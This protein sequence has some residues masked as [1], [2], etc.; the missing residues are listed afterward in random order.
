MSLKKNYLIKK[1]NI[2]SYFSL[3]NY[4]PIIIMSILIVVLFIIKNF[5]YIL[6]LNKQIS[7]IKEIKININQYNHFLVHL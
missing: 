6:L 1:Y 4:D 5:F 3:I 2:A 7:F